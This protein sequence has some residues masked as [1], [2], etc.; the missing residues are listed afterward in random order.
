[1]QR[2]LHSL[3]QRLGIPEDRQFATKVQLGW[4]MIQR[5]LANGLPFEALGCDDL[6]GR[7]NWFRG[8]AAKAGIVYLADVPVNTQV[9]LSPPAVRVPTVEPGRKGRPPSRQRVLSDDK[10]LTAREVFALKDTH[11]QR[12]RS[13]ERGEID[14]EFAVR[15][16]WTDRDEPG[17]PSTEEWLVIRREADGKLNCSP[18]NAPA[19]S[20]VE[21]LAWLRCQ[22]YFVERANQDS[23]TE[24]GWDEF[25]AQKYLAWQ[26]QLAL[27]VLASW[28][29][30]ETKLDWARK[31][32]RDPKLA[33]EFEVEVLP[34]LS[35][36]NVR[37]MLRAAMPLPQL[38]P[39]QAT[40]L[41]VKHL[42][43]RTRAKRSR[44]CV[45]SDAKTTGDEAA[46]R[47][48]P[49]RF[50]ANRLS[51]YHSAEL[52]STPPHPLP[53]LPSQHQAPN[54]LRSPAARLVSQGCCRRAVSSHQV[55]HCPEHRCRIRLVAASPSRATVA[56][57]PPGRSPPTGRRAAGRA[58][59]YGCLS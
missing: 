11:R 58:R 59:W 9:Y 45:P 46:S 44:M 37:E 35:V 21:Q 26:H 36:A 47:N 17:V 50:T 7:S 55:T 25:R 4:Q 12:V 13:T 33:R 31:V 1:M 40:E 8:N 28:F 43:N 42:V 49:G 10:P 51:L 6:Y 20:T 54:L 19:E 34:M 29:I 22:R 41:V 52:A 14:D 38:T 53:S 56:R 23:K 57:S 48:P 39:E 3:R 5:A 18:S 24:M 27:T 2:S 16:V 30:A 15:R 32:G